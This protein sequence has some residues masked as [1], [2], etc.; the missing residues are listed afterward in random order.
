MPDLRR[1]ATATALL[2]MAACATLSPAGA[3]TPA[4][5]GAAQPDPVF[6]AA[7]KA[8]EALSDAERK[9]I[10]DDLVWAT[11]FRGGTSGSFGPLTF[12]AVS[13]FQ[14][15]TGATVDGNLKPEQRA[16]IAAAAGKARASAKFSVVVDGKTGV[17][18]GV[19][20]R[21][22]ARTMAGATGTRWASADN[23]IS[24]ET[25]VENGTPLAALFD[26][27][28]AP[29]P[30]R[31]VT[32]KLL[33]P[34]WFVVTADTAGQRT[35]VRYAAVGQALKGFVF[36]YPISGGPEFDRLAVAI[37]NSFDPD[38]AQGGA[39][40]ASS[41]PQQGASAQPVTPAAAQR[42]LP[43]GSGLIATGVAIAPGK[44]LT[45]ASVAGCAT[46][47][48]ATLPAKVAA[49]DKDAG[50]A[51]L[52]V[53]GLKARP[54]A[55]MPGGAAEGASLVVIGFAEQRQGAPQLVVAPGEARVP[56]GSGTLRVF[57][58]L[59]HGAAGSLVLDRQGG[60]AGV[61]S[62][63]AQEPRLVAGITPAASWPVVKTDAVAR[64]LQQA[65]TNLTP[66]SP[67]S[68]SLSA[69]DLAQALKFS[70]VAVTCG[71]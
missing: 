13:A 59:Q 54:A 66:G 60:L 35:Y 44:V 8:F 26:R 25:G 53:A 40:A 5:A 23:A 42:G 58:P 7:Q 4:P 2:M 19:P 63:T 9:A 45:T 12:R 69:G 67:P 64:L 28:N 55:L 21:P 68:A 33:R 32:Y 65:G 56:Q 61:V 20:Q 10:Q 37:A 15:Q 17:R 18:I 46:I 38:P 47:N 30:N 3:Q 14:K 41:P 11:D 16:T 31:K 70:L 39:V 49:S 57:A 50:L 27:F 22:L 1:A 43:G 51:V 36:S 71:G 24:L 48:A 52:D 34:D 62:G 29:A 6:A